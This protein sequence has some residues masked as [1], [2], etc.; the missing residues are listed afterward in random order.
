MKSN[1]FLSNLIVP[2]ALIFP[3]LLLFASVT[4][5]VKTI[6]P[7]ENLVQFEP[8][9]TAAAS[10]LIQ[11]PQTPYNALLSD[12]VLENY[13]WKRFINH[14]IETRQI[15]LWNPYLFAGTP[16]LGNGQHSI[17]YP[18]SIFFYLLP[19]AKAYGW[20]ILSQYS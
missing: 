18:F 1:K 12:L 20:F 5:G 2:L 8:W 6:I 10:F 16:F 3:P 11:A 15:P 9:K 14:A 13:A 4:I 7:T 17:F 19:L